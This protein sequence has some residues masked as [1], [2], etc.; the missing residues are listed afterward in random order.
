[1]QDDPVGLTRFQVVTSPCSVLFQTSYA[2]NSIFPFL[3]F[4][5]TILQ[6][7][8][9]FFVQSIHRFQLLLINI[10]PA[11]SGLSAIDYW[12]NLFWTHYQTTSSLH[13]PITPSGAL[14]PPTKSPRVV[15]ELL[16]FIH[17]SASPLQLVALLLP[18]P[19]GTNSN[20]ATI[21]DVVIRA[22]QACDGEPRPIHKSTR[23]HGHNRDQFPATILVHTFHCRLKSPSMSTEIAQNTEQSHLARSPSVEGGKSKPPALDTSG[24][25]WSFC[26]LISRRNGAQTM[27][28]CYCCILHGSFS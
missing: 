25:M 7:L 13:A 27:R 8:L 28:N 17:T 18:S 26:H 9:H 2:A 19:S 4:N 15:T 10:S 21:C 11:R 5:H 1:M 12:C 14:P 20:C 24:C 6:I 16:H 23:E 22:D 3:S